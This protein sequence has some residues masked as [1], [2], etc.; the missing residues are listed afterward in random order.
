LRLVL[1]GGKGSKTARSHPFSVNQLLTARIRDGFDLGCLVY[2]Q[3]AGLRVAP[4]RSGKA[5]MSL[6][7]SVHWIR[8]GKSLRF[9]KE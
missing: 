6:Q 7:R 4:E 9:G 2:R 8:L 1:I 3:P 5:C